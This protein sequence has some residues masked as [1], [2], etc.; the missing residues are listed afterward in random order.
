[1]KTLLALLALLLPA[2]ALAQE[3]QWGLNVYLFSYH[4]DRD[5]AKRLG[6]DTEVNPGLGLRYR[7]LL[8]T[9]VEGFLDAGAYRDSGR[10]TAVYAAGGA[11][12]R[13]TE[14]LR[15]GAALALLHSDTYNHG[16][17]FIAPVPLATYDFDRITFNMV[18]LPKVREFNQIN[19]LGF[20]ATVWIK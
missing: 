1:M 19:T 3:G 12:Y 8:D 20:W 9:N 11:L 2:A 10:N 6:V 7:K 13:V 14:R 17:A 4:F 16:K 15:L 18:Y 5:K